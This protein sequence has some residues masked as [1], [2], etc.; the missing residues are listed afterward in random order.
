[1][2]TVQAEK[3]RRKV[4]DQATAVAVAQI[5]SADLRAEGELVAGRASQIDIPCVCIAVFGDRHVLV[6]GGVAA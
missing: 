2:V 1:M 6:A 3:D 4:R 5:G